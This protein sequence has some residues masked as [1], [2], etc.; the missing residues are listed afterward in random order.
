MSNAFVAGSP[1]QPPEL[2]KSLFFNLS[3]L[4]ICIVLAHAID[5]ATRFLSYPIG[6]WIMTCMIRNVGM[7]AARATGGVAISF[8][9]LGMM[10]P[11][12]GQVFLLRDMPLLSPM[13]LIGQAT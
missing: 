12:A 11:L 4:T 7:P 13:S 9:V 10:A 6:Y 2:V 1:L 5:H 3:G 8:V